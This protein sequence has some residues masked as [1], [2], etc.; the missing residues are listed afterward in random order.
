VDVS[1]PLPPDERE[2]QHSRLRSDIETI[3]V[4]GDAHRDE[5][6]EVLVE[7]EPTVHIVAL[8]A[9][10]RL[11]LHDRALRALVDHPGSLE[12]RRSKFSR[13]QLETILG[14]ARQLSNGPGTFLSSGIGRGKLNLQLG[15]DQ[16]TLAATLLETFGEAV[17]VKVGAF[18][19]PMP[20]DSAVRPPILRPDVLPISLEGLDVSLSDN[21]TVASGRLAHGSLE[22]SNHGTDE[23]TLDTNGGV[24]ARILDPSTLDVVGGFVGAQAMPLIRSPIAPGETVTVR[25][26]V[27]T[28][29]FKRDLGYTVPPGEWMMDAIVKVH[30]RGRRRVPPLP[31]IIV[32]RSLSRS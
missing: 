26:L 14:E 29:S 8:F 16:E 15:A 4:Y 28:A 19:F 1:G 13:I 3:R 24:T 7:N 2:F 6:T 32:A 22:F 17:D 12:V 10:P 31:V 25:L 20:T 21:V 11:E 18:A 23:V 27:G 5:W 30:D 9:G